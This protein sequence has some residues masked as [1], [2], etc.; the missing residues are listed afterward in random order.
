M[1]LGYNQA[2][3]T[4]QEDAESKEEDAEAVMVATVDE[5]V[6]VVVWERRRRLRITLRTRS[7]R[8]D[9]EPSKHLEEYSWQVVTRQQQG[10]QHTP[11]L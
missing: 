8:V 2:A 5:D 3:D 10:R 7:K 9:I 4:M 1:A 6:D 11:T